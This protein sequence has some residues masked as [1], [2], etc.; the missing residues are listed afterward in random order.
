MSSAEVLAPAAPPAQAAPGAAA[1][2]TAPVLAAQAAAANP[3]AGAPPLLPDILSFTLPALTAWLTAHGQKSFRARQIFRWLYQKHVASFEEMTDIA[4]P[5]RALLAQSFSLGSLE[6]AAQA[7]S[8]DGSRKFAFRLGDGKRIE[9]VLMPNATHYTLCVST[10]VGCAMGCAF[11]MTARMGLER[12]LTAGEIVAQ[13]VACARAIPDEKILRNLVFM[14]MGEPFHNYDNLVAALDILGEDHGF[15][16]SWRRMTVSTAGLVPA[17]RRFGQD[18]VRANLAISLNGA[19]D[20]VRGRLMPVNRRW[21]L[22]ELLAACREFPVESRTRLTFEYVLIQGITDSLADARRLVKLLHGMKCK[23]NLIPYNAG[24]DHPFQAP[25]PEHV[26]AFQEELLNRG[27]LATV[28]ISKGQ[29][30]AA[31]CGQLVTE[32]RRGRLPAMQA[33]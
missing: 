26:R 8:A 19:S 24:P 32:L 18:Q 27:L 2:P 1:P 5:L 17:I 10:Q 9:S 31:A 33:G 29:D 14:G 23:V 11:C 22:A 6:P 15:G 30:I 13:V 12:N 3:A 4:K 16:F 7:D 20:E 25:P 28:R 21:P